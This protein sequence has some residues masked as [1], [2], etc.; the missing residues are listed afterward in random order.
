MAERIPASGVARAAAVAS[1]A[2]IAHQVGG[3]AARDAL[4]LSNFD[5]T[6]LPLML[7]GAAALSLFSA[8]IASRIMTRSSP[9]LVVPA[10]FAVSGALQ[11]LEWWL[12]SVS[13]AAASIAIYCH[14]AVFG[15]VLV[16]G[17]W[18]LY[19]EKL[20]PRS[21]KLHI[22][23]VAGGGTL[24][25]LLGGLLAERLADPASMLP[26]LA[27]LHFFCAWMVLA[28][29]S[30]EEGSAARPDEA[31]LERP[32]SEK[33]KPDWGLGIFRRET[34]LRNL[35]LLVLLGTASAALID[36]VFKS[37]AQSHFLQEGQ[38]D[39]AGLLRFF[40]LF[41]MGTGVLTFLVQTGLSRKAL[42][43]LGLAR[44][45]ASLP[46]LTA[47]GAAAAAVV[48]GLASCAI[49]RGA[50]AVMK[51][52]LFRSG[53]ELFFTPVPANEKRASK[54]IIDVGFERL[55]D[56]LG[57]G[58][59][60]LLLLLPV[61]FLRPGM[62][63][64][65]AALS[66]V[67][68][69]ITRA[70]HFGYVRALER[71]L[72]DRAMKIDPSLASDRTTRTT[73]LQ[74]MSSFDVSELSEVSKRDRDSGEARGREAAAGAQS[75]SASQAGLRVSDP[76]LMQVAELRSGQP[77]RVLRSLE[78]HPILDPSL[79]G[80]VIPLLAWDRISQA[81]VECLRNISPQI[82]G[83]LI[84]AILDR[85][86]EFAIRRRIP[87]ILAFCPTQRAAEGLL[88]A[89]SDPRFEVRF[90]S[91][92]ALSFILQRNPKISLRPERIF[93]IV[94]REVDVD[95]RIWESQR[96]LD[97][98]DDEG[99]PIVDDVLRDRS[100]RSLEHVFTVLSLVLE[101]EPLRIAFRGLH[102]ED[103]KLRG[104]ALEYLES[105]LPQSVREKLWPFLEDSDALP[106]GVHRSR[107]EILAELM[108][109]NHSIEISLAEL[110]IEAADRSQFDPGREED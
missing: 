18:S 51:S 105:V 35:G 31:S 39:V 26:A 2:M 6:R 104:T 71:S 93:D 78:G 54:T 75:S 10:A 77:E 90:Q 70:L 33:R 56:M 87:R 69:G 108:Q 63:A 12:A 58:I 91:G 53:Y 61:A 102:T 60:W 34:Y 96:L 68:L 5:V 15:S 76:V 23:K 38:L 37:S 9:S 52:S 85:R 4:F 20:D 72:V 88:E 84:D 50:E 98:L 24:G 99:S 100:N 107:E 49:A 97:R 57:A 8:L 81:A 17:F 29:R 109:S 1:A 65:A 55:G 30:S 74:T 13:P 101:R 59:A 32:A 22:S 83:Q 42:E 106:S 89:L 67:C 27:I 79:A 46:A 95:R 21:A 62:L 41:Y 66:L 45:A 7:A 43:T 14:I 11:L 110:Q 92:R 48:P 16:S 64:V 25:G 28:L 44:T 47:L 94:L 40:A 3:K 86:Q 19:N 80:H 36:Y 73:L 82:S 103:K